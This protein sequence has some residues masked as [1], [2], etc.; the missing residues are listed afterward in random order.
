MAPGHSPG[1]TDAEHGPSVPHALR[2]LA[3]FPSGSGTASSASCREEQEEQ[4]AHL[5]VNNI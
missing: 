2:E 3:S 1:A 5:L 4:K